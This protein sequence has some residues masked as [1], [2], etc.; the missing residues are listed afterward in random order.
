[1]RTAL[2]LLACTFSM[3]CNISFFKPAR[4]ESKWEKPYAYI[5]TQ[6]L[7]AIPYALEVQEDRGDTKAQR[8]KWCSDLRDKGK[9]IQKVWSDPDTVNRVG[10]SAIMLVSMLNMFPKESENKGLKTI[11]KLTTDYQFLGLM[12]QTKSVVLEMPSD[13]DAWYIRKVK[14]IDPTN[15]LNL[16]GVQ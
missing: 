4:T 14:S 3:S 1:M 12:L 10:Q 2:L 16:L 6:I 15:S 9:G 5:R 11:R 7:I 8:L 13:W